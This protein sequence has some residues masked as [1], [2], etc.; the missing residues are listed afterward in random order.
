M[1][2]FLNELLYCKE[3]GKLSQSLHFHLISN[4]FLCRKP[5]T[6]YLQAFTTRAV[7]QFESTNHDPYLPAKASPPDP[8]NSKCDEDSFWRIY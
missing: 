8:Q 2:D 4:F 1:S 3:N 6:D 7:N 5:L